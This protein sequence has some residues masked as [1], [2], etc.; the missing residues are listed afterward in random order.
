VE[1]GWIRN[2]MRYTGRLG[3]IASPTRE[4]LD[5][6]RRE[7]VGE[8]H[9]GGGQLAYY[10]RKALERTK[11]WRSTAAIGRFCLWAGIT[12]AILLALFGRL[13]PPSSQDLALSC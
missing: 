9:P 8:P 5:F 4:G 2:V 13:M 1:L 10:E 6:A 3:D 7:W 12:V 11:L